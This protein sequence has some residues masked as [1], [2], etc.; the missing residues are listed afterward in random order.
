SSETR[1]AADLARAAAHAERQAALADAREKLAAAELELAAVQAND[2]AQQQDGNADAAPANEAAQKQLAE[3]QARVEAARKTLSAAEQAAAADSSAYTPLGPTYPATSTGRRL[4]LARWITDRHHPL[5]ARVAVN[6]IWLRHF[7]Q[8]LVESVDDFGLRATRPPLADVLD[9]LAVELMEHGWSMKHIHR[10]IVTSGAYQMASHAG[11]ASELAEQRDRDNHYLW[12]RRPQRLEAEA[13]RDALLHLPG[14][15]DLTL[16]GP[17]IDHQQGLAVARRSLY[18][19]HARERQVELL[20]LFDAASPR[21]CYRRQQSIRPQQALALIHSSLSLAQAR[22]LA[23]R[24]SAELDSIVAFRSAKV[25]DIVAF[26]SAKVADIEDFSHTQSTNQ[27]PRYFRGAKGDNAES[28][29]IIA[30]FETI[31]SRAP[32]EA[33]LHECQQFLQQQTQLLAD[34][35]QLEPIGPAQDPVP[36]AA[37]PAQRARE[38]L[39]LVL[40]NHNDFLTVR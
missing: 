33:E 12:R 17:D 8:P 37:D 14:N 3:I 34:P 4:A 30:A 40:L 36:P 24:L 31:L 16:G 2:A 10:L 20:Q 1:D 25:A 28:Q 7:G 9:Y 15:L 6:H 13:I 22:H 27:P 38:N 29:F 35:A 19:R 23:A 39:V 26:R 18:F 21:E 5:T 32:S 11:S